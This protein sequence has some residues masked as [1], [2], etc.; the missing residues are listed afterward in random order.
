MNKL[1][2]RSGQ[3]HLVKCRVDAATVIEAGDMVWLDADDAKPASAFAWTTNL[4]TTQGNFAAKF[5]GIA[6]QQ[7]VPG[8]TAPISVDISPTSVYEMD[9]SSSTYEVGSPLAPDDQSNSLLDQQL[10]TVA[11]AANAIARSVEFQAQSTSTLR[12]TFGSAFS[13]GSGNTN[14]AIG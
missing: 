3:V 14:A 12:V 11:S 13:T 10:E 6:H 1:R 7:S 8:D 4:A 2:F 5:L 9:V